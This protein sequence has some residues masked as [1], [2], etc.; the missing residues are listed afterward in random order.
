M[1]MDQKKQYHT[2]LTLM[3]NENKTNINCEKN[4]DGDIIVDAIDKMKLY[5]YLKRECQ[6]LLNVLQ[7]I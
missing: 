6:K 4:S 5:G 7:I 1:N 3:K 2:Y